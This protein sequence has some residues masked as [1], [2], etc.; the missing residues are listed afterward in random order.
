MQDS[1]DQQKKFISREKEKKVRYSP[2]QARRHSSSNNNGSTWSF[3][4]NGIFHRHPLFQQHQHP[5]QQQLYLQLFK[6]QNSATTVAPIAKRI[7]SVSIS[8]RQSSWM[9]KKSANWKTRHLSG[10]INIPLPLNIRA[11]SVWSP[12][13]TQYECWLIDFLLYY[14]GYLGQIL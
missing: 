14:P 12:V 1:R 2:R 7:K 5:S 11:N 9:A 6:Q 3:L 10:D 8:T 13:K 4:W